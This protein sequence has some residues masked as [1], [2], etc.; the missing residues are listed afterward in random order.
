MLHLQALELLLHLP[1]PLQLRHRFGI[2]RRRSTYQFAIAYLLAPARQ[3]ERMNAQRL[4]N[5]LDQNARLVTHL[6]CLQLESDLVPMNLL[7]SWCAHS[8]P[9]SL[10]ESVNKT[11]SRSRSVS[12]ASWLLRVLG[13]RD[14]QA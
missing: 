10:G 9:S 8:T 14:R 11:D 6:H 1:Q 3:H 7:R 5:V 12:C 4:G 2:E 13:W